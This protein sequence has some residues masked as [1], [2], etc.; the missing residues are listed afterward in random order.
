M[1]AGSPGRPLRL[2]MVGGG[3]GAFIGP[4]HRIAATMDGHF[5]LTAGAFASDPERSVQSGLALGLDP[6]RCYP[7]YRAMAAGEAGR[8]DGI[9]AVSIVTT[10][11]THLAIA[12]TFLAAGID[13]ICEKPMTATLDEARQLAASVASSGRV[14]VLTHNYTGYPMVRE[15]RARV[16]DGQIGRLRVVQ[17]EY[18]QGWLSEPVE[19]QSKQAAWR[20]DP[21]QAG[22]GGAL[23]DIGT[24][25]FHLAGYVTGAGTEAVLA[26]LSC[27]GHGRTL[28][29]NAH[30]LLRLAGGARGV[31]WASQVAVG[32]LNGLRLRVYGET[33]A[34]E[35]AQEQPNT[36]VLDRPGAP[37]MLLATGSP[38]LS[39][40]ATRATRLPA[41]H[42]EGFLEAFANIY[43]DAAA[44][45][46][47]RLGG[48]P[49]VQD[50][51]ATLGFV[52]ACV[53]SHAAGGIWQRL[54][55]V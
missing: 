13:V 48:T 50:G 6:A 35:W 46:R 15:A 12:Q 21:A 2:G 34:L 43:A 10:N 52:D 55:S 30:V 20:V 47:A 53:R 37:R 49:G 24:H 8:P 4:V 32:C 27:F 17:V 5:R 42:P 7:D 54:E 36:L 16:A 40:A 11:R 9:E 38:G 25:A 29:D 22:A 41:G 23:G 3:S 51:L 31:L 14:F 19:R 28:D 39:E 18:A 45:I 33:G 26:D 44:A 1:S